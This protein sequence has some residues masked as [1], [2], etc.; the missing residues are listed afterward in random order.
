MGFSYDVSAL[1]DEGLNRI[2]MELGDVDENDYFLQDEEIEQILT[3]VSSFNAY[4]YKCCKLILIRISTKRKYIIEGYSEDW[5]T[6]YKR[7][8]KMMNHY[9]RLCAGSY[10]ISSSIS[11]DDRK[12][13]TDD[14][15]IVQPKFDKGMHDY[16]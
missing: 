1:N 7:Y 16:T 9:G 6:V 2:R 14:T 5:D 10:P 11:V 8:E 12:I 13:Y 15:S 3:E 4:L